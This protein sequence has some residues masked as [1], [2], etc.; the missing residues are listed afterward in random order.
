MR[1]NDIVSL[2]F[3]FCINSFLLG[4]GLAADA[5]SVCIANAL[6]E[7]DMKR[8]RQ[9]AVASVYAIFQFAMPLIG[10]FFAR[11]LSQAFNA[12]Q[13]FIPW[14]AFLLLLYLGTKMIVEAIRAKR[15]ACSDCK[16]NSCQ[17]CASNTRGPL[18]PSVLLLQGL[19]TSIDALSAGWTVA[20][21]R[22]PM[23]ARAALIIAAV[24]F[25]ICL[26][27]LKIGKAAG[28]ALSDRAQVFGGCI[29]ILIGIEIFVRS[30]F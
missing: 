10:W 24:T 14:I 2:N 4:V 21:Y 15:G 18:T 9:C 25:A 17:D 19:A 6:A 7:P 22:A 3:F 5:F 13:K 26:V 11:S 30:R 23:A 1:Y 28:K 8:P 29:L 20:Q 12:L 27:G 16:K